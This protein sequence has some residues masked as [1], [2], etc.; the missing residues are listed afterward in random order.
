MKYRTILAFQ[1]VNLMQW[2][3]LKT[4][5]AVRL[6]GSGEWR[7]PFVEKEQMQIFHLGFNIY[8]FFLAYIL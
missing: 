5:Y 7:L 8:H 1:F 2:R 4:T 3:V 6:A